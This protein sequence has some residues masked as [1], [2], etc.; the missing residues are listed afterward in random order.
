[1][2]DQQSLGS[3]KSVDCFN[4]NA[5]DKF[6]FAT[7]NCFGIFL[8]PALLKSSHDLHLKMPVNQLNIINPALAN[9]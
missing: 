3:L 7:K 8:E 6:A 9:T 1:M 2:P 5:L 4:L